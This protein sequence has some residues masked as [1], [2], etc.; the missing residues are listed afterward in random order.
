MLMRGTGTR[1]RRGE[2]KQRKP[3]FYF[4]FS[5]SWS[6]SFAD[7]RA[8]DREIRLEKKEEEEERQG[9]Q[10]QISQFGLSF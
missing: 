6:D 5:T 1:N 10:S 9:T 7:V 8:I 4:P 2:E 3:L